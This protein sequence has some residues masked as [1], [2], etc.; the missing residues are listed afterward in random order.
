MNINHAIAK[1][2]DDLRDLARNHNDVPRIAWDHLADVLG[3][4]PNDFDLISEL[5]EEVA[6][7]EEKVAELESQLEEVS[8]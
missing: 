8:A 3:D 2:A 1:I 7:L 4:R 6:E 5:K